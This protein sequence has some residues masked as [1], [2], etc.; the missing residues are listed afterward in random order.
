MAKSE[1]D[2]TPSRALVRQNDLVAKMAPVI[3]MEQWARSIAYG[4]P[5]VEP[6]PDFVAR[7][8]AIMAMTAESVDDILDAQGVKGLQR[9][10]PDRESESWGPFIITNLY[11]ARSDFAT[12]NGTF[13]IM[14]V[15]HLETGEEHKIS[16]GATNIQSSLI[17]LISLEHWPI[18]AKFKRGTVKDRGERYLLHLIGP[19]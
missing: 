19:D 17:G 14:T 18:R 7:N 8:L 10:V 4:E 12:G 6:D 9:L 1:L 3:D 15:S 16:T 13:V 2:R 5:Y 11:V